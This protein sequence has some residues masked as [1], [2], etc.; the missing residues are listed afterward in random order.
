MHAW[1]PPVASTQCG[2]CARC[3]NE[4]QRMTSIY[5]AFVERRAC[6][7]DCN[8][9]AGLAPGRASAPD[10]PSR[11]SHFRIN[12]S[13]AHHWFTIGRKHLMVGARCK[14]Y[15]LI[16]LYAPTRHLYRKKVGAF[17]SGASRFQSGQ[18][19]GSPAT[20]SQAMLMCTLE[21]RNV[22]HTASSTPSRQCYLVFI[23]MAHMMRSRRD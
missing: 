5:M 20:W 9:G 3:L 16:Q 14:L 13:Q 11:V 6:L 12:I 22:W 21:H 8:V 7:C 1:H 4:E 18:G 23:H 19:Q 2:S 10:V 17:M 15:W